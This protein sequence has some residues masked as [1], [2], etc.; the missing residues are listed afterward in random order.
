MLKTAKIGSTISKIAF[1]NVF[2]SLI[3]IFHFQITRYSKSFQCGEDSEA[4]AKAGEAN[5][6]IAAEDTAAV[7]ETFQIA[8]A[9]GTFK[10]HITDKNPIR[11]QMWNGMPMNN[12]MRMPLGGMNNMGPMGGRMPMGGMQNRPQ[13]PAQRQVPQSSKKPNSHFSDWADKLRRSSETRKQ[14]AKIRASAEQAGSAAGAAEKEAA[15]RANGLR[16]HGRRFRMLS[17]YAESRRGDAHHAAH[18]I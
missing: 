6:L 4:S 10:F 9:T 11:Q 3:P 2:S 8:E 15:A 18:G 16:K 12:G 13:N 7:E 14:R 17:V 1:E 5:N